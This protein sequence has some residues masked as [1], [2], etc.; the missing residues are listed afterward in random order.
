ML[1]VLFGCIRQKKELWFIRWICI[2]TFVGQSN[3]Y[4]KSLRMQFVPTL[5]EYL[6]HS[7]TDLCPARLIYCIRSIY[8]LICSAWIFKLFYCKWT[9]FY[10]SS[11][12]FIIRDKY[13]RKCNITLLQAISKTLN[14]IAVNQLCTQEI[15][16][17][18][19][20]RKGAKWKIIFIIF[21]LICMCL[22]I[23]HQKRI[24]LIC[25][26]SFKMRSYKRAAF[27][28]LPSLVV[29]EQNALFQK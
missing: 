16:R 23:C 8:A 22:E 19:C 28:F 24:F 18:K 26:L 29:D 7:I 21:F 27:L 20:S 2:K 4:R 5:W 10:F 6:S 15:I 3:F 13:G 17:F 1:I 12:L 11:F 25:F 14:T 9:D